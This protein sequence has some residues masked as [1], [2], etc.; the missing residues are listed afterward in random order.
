MRYAKQFGIPL[1]SF[2]ELR[3]RA[4]EAGYG[5]A[6]PLS[7]YT[8]IRGLTAKYDRKEE[9]LYLA[10]TA[11]RS[12]IALGASPIPADL[13]DAE[14]V[15]VKPTRRG[16]I[17][18]AYARTK[19]IGN[20]AL[21]AVPDVT[22]GVEPGSVEEAPGSLAD[23]DESLLVVI[24]PDETE[25]PGF[26]YKEPLLTFFR[27]GKA[28]YAYVEEQSNATLPAVIGTI[29]AALSPVT[30]PQS[31]PG[32]TVTDLGNGF[33]SVSSPMPVPASA[34]F[35]AKPA[36]PPE[37]EHLGVTDNGT[38]AQRFRIGLQGYFDT[39][40]HDIGNGLHTHGGRIP[41]N[42]YAVQG[43]PSVS[44]DA[45]TEKLVIDFETTRTSEP[46]RAAPQ[47]TGKYH[48][49]EPVPDIST[50]L[51]P[52][53]A[54]YAPGT[55]D[56]AHH[57]FALIVS[58]EKMEGRDLG[59]F[60]SAGKRPVL[61]FTHNGKKHYVY[62]EVQTRSYE[63][64]IYDHEYRIPL[65]GIEQYQDGHEMWVAGH[66][67]VFV[68][69]EELDPTHI[70]VRLSSNRKK[71]VVNAG[72]RRYGDFEFC[73]RE[74]KDAAICQVKRGSVEAR[75]HGE[76]LEYGLSAWDGAAEFQEIVGIM[77]SFMPVD[78]YD[79]MDDAE[80]EE[81][82]ARNYGAGVYVGSA[83]NYAVFAAYHED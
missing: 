41:L 5:G 14:T 71:I 21:V 34:N 48:R 13:A 47:A 57:Q 83:G 72:L 20:R 60:S 29:D 35:T 81:W 6:I 11:E 4:P 68:D 22:E 42:G 77:L 80:I 26:V 40:A 7:G 50:G 12:N 82:L 43:K 49:I 44:F 9:T 3:D 73:K 58:E 65:E 19:A 1:R 38:Y 30:P 59:A 62:L 15:P 27:D 55:A 75:D 66:E 52:S 45:A 70:S 64:D 78:E 69:F 24:L 54:E 63:N 46:L 16:D 17:H 8:D 53:D 18:T 79:K 56:V 31:A 23:K 61:T 74:F 67:P 28:F 32:S 25:I 39:I 37:V 51:S 36:S 76:E 33:V 10:F 2:Y